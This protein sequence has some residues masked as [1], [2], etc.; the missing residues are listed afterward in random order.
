MVS[1]KIIIIKKKAEKAKKALLQNL[2]NVWLKKSPY[3]THGGSANSRFIINIGKCTPVKLTVRAV[4]STWRKE[5]LQHRVFDGKLSSILHLWTEPAGTAAPR[6]SQAD[7][8][9]KLEVA[10]G[11]GMLKG[12]W[13]LNNI[14]ASSNLLSAVKVSGSGSCGLLKTA[15]GLM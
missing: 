5:S 1:S 11:A 6:Y 15:A 12:R 4:C 14:S 8:G 3:P 2:I 13:L 7:G 9:T 10:A